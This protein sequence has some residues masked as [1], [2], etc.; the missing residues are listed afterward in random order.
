MDLE[1]NSGTKECDSELLEKLL[2][3]K[4]PGL[5]TDYENNSRYQPLPV[6]LFLLYFS[7]Q[8]GSC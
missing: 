5:H 1:E 6:C 3:T 4:S 8:Y 7:V 2:I